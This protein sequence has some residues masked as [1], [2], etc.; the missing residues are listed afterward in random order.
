MQK[1]L[2]L[3]KLKTTLKDDVANYSLGDISL[4]D[5][6]GKDIRIEYL[7][8]I[9]CI[10]CGVKTKKSYSQGHCFLCARRLPECDICI[11]KPELCHFEEG[12]CRD[13]SWGEDNCM[14]THI[15]YLANTGD[16]KVGITKLKNIPSRWIDQGA[17]KALAIF[18]VENRL[19]SGLVEVAIK[20]HISDKTNWRKMLQGDPTNDIDLYKLRDEIVEKAQDKID[21][22]KAKH[23]ENSVEFVEGDI[24]NISY[25]VT[26]YPTKI[27][28]FNFDKTPIIDAKLM[29]V[30]GQYFIFD[31][32]VVN[33]RKF[34][35]YKCDLKFS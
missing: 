11:L 20:E 14:K 5:Y 1:Q 32:G 4:N 33:I 16:V 31:T 13:S 3:H 34:S 29:G 8:E 19:I 22:I 12:T 2:N 9:N 25:P 26:N 15:V 18:A 28:S 24:C 27:K 35:G 7:G 23:G 21:A 6:I 10:S 17:S 30:K